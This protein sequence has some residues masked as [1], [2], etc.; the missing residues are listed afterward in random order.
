M[1]ITASTDIELFVPGRLCIVGEHTDWIGGHRVNNSALPM[2]YTLVCATNEGLY[3][4]VRPILQP[5]CLQFISSLTTSHL[6]NETNSSVFDPSRNAIGS[7]PA[8]DRS[9]GAASIN[10]S[11]R[12]GELLHM[13]RT[14][15]FFSYVAGTALAVLESRY[16]KDKYP[17]FD[18]DSGSSSSGTGSSSGSSS[19]SGNGNDN[20]DSGVSCVL[21]GICIDNYL[22]TLPMQKG[23]SSSAAVCVLTVKAFIAYYQLS[24]DI[25]LSELMELAFRGEMYT[26]SRCG[27]MDQCVVMGAQAVGIMTFDGLQPADLRV[28]QPAAPLHFVVV[29]LHA[30]KDTVCILQQLNDCFPVPANETQQL[31]H[32]YAAAIVDIAEQVVA[33]IESGDVPKLGHLMRQA[34]FEFDRC[35]TDNCPSQLTAPVLHSLMSDTVLMGAGGSD[36]LAYAVKG[37]GSQGDGSAQVKCCEGVLQYPIT[38][39]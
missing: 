32:Q 19:S 22:T 29:D 9:E 7:M 36:G 30:F 1:N 12:R 35:A 20:L 26:P 4:R 38:D 15:G 10:A 33:A 34:Q 16:F 24:D 14:G 31:M 25:S 6:N 3:A 2:G 27:R 28:L 23:L 8:A 11:F 18:I 13:A 5:A 37:I 17:D 21:P 39:A